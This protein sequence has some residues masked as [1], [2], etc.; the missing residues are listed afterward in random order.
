MFECSAILD[1]IERLKLAE[2]DF[3]SLQ[4]KLV[5]LGKMLSALIR[6]IEKEGRKEFGPPRG[7]A[8][9]GLG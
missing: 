7:Y 5:H 3:G 1:L 4:D 6:F 8:A 9:V 2:A